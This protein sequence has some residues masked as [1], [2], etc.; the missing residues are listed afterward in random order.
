MDLSDHMKETIVGWVFLILL[1]GAGIISAAPWDRPDKG[2]GYE[3]T[4]QYSLNTGPQ[5]D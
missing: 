1:F 2:S 4:E 5:C 3:C